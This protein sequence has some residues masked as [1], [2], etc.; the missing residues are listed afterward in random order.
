MY[1]TDKL[2]WNLPILMQ[3]KEATETQMEDRCWSVLVRKLAGI[4]YEP[5]RIANL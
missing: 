4:K 1:E 2:Q 3:L 5:T